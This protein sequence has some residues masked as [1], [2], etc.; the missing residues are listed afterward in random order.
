MKEVFING[1]DIYIVIVMKVFGVE[2]DQVDSLM[3]C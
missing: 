2:V 3:C 1:D